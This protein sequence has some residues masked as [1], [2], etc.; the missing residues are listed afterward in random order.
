MFVPGDIL[1]LQ[2]KNVNR[3]LTRLFKPIMRENELHQFGR[4]VLFVNRHNFT[5]FDFWAACCF[6]QFIIFVLRGSN[7]SLV[8]IKFG[9]DKLFNNKSLQGFMAAFVV[10]FFADDYLFV[11]CEHRKLSF[12]S[13]IV[14]RADWRCFGI[15]ASLETGWQFNDAIVFKFWTDIALFFFQCLYITSL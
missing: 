15:T 6:T 7:R 1:R 12:S 3:I 14:R 10:C 5:G 11:C 2:N 8:G 4:H 13:G 9:K